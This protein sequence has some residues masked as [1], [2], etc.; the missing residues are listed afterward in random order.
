[1][2]WILVPCLVSLRDEFN[3]L[4]PTRDKA[5]DGS[6]GDTSHAASSSDHNPDETGNTPY[7]DSDKVNEVHAIDVDDDLRKSGWSMQKCVDIIVGR[8]REGRDD[9]LQNIIYNRR[10]WSR[11]WDWSAREYTGSNPHDKHAHFSSRYT[12]A[13]ESDASPWGLLEADKGPTVV[14]FEYFNAHLPVIKYGQNDALGII[15]ED[16]KRDM[17]GYVR[18]IQTMVD[19]MT[20]GEIN[21]DGVF[22]KQTKAAIA[23]LGVSGRDG[24]LV[25]LQVWT[26]LYAL[27]GAHVTAT[28]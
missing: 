22:G 4:A 10:I 19:M 7:S 13:Q 17:T 11:S 25:D 18:R 23:K 27:W 26:K 24:S 21:V 8:H 6:I 5:S 14:K 9:R 1:M 28:R 16:G 20:P 12:T 15:G 3:R 2:S